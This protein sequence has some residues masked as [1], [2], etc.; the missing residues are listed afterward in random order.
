MY[1]LIIYALLS[2]A[3]IPHT[4]LFAA[5]SKSDLEETDSDRDLENI[6]LLPFGV[7]HFRQEIPLEN[8]NKKVIVSSYRKSSAADA[9][10]RIN[11]YIY[12]DDIYADDVKAHSRNR[13]RNQT[14]EASQNWIEPD[15]RIE[16]SLYTY[17]IPINIT[18][19]LT[20]F[21]PPEYASAIRSELK[22]PSPS[23]WCTTRPKKPQS[24]EA[25]LRHITIPW[26]TLEQ[27]IYA[28]ICYTL[29]NKSVYLPYFDSCFQPS[30]I[31]LPSVSAILCEKLFSKAIPEKELDTLHYDQVENMAYLIY[32][33]AE[34]KIINLNLASTLLT[35]LRDEHRIDTTTIGFKEIRRAD[36]IE[37]FERMKIVIG[38]AFKRADQLIPDLSPSIEMYSAVLSTDEEIKK[39]L[40]TPT[41]KD[42]LLYELY[43]L[44]RN[45]IFSEKTAYSKNRAL[46]ILDFLAKTETSEKR[47]TTWLQKRAR[48]LFTHVQSCNTSEDITADT[49]VGISKDDS[50]EQDSHS[51]LEVL[52]IDTGLEVLDID[53][54]IEFCLASLDASTIK[55]GSAHHLLHHEIISPMMHNNPL[56]LSA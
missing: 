27:G 14:N 20:V 15:K 26:V 4:T 38:N 2:S 11:T 39:I 30:Y 54:G 45:T 56:L 44:T 31:L 5:D 23:F 35:H 7:G 10:P 12:P 24:V 8:Q 33:Y 42:H 13:C 47:T 1:H 52:D 9:L 46:A 50:M 36:V 17:W 51:N 43:I 25:L 40:Q 22:P 34:R 48:T 55:R 49:P 37:T 53:T 21:L 32:Q 41:R 29:F 16:Q 6:K 18:T 19:S 28:I 3:F